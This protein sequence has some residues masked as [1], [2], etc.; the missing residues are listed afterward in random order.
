MSL[1]LAIERWI[2]SHSLSSTLISKLPTLLQLLYDHDVIQEDALL[3]W[4]T[5]PLPSTRGQGSD[6]HDISS[7][8]PTSIH[9]TSVR[10][11][12]APFIEWLRTADEE[13]DDNDE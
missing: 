12:A 7:Y 6:G 9:S 13:N 3:S 4:H 10:R 11:A 8:M 1:M 5:S 2:G